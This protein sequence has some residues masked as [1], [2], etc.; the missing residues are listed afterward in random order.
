M[1]P[2]SLWQLSTDLDVDNGKAN[3]TRHRP[4]ELFLEVTLCLDLDL[5]KEIIDMNIVMKHVDHS[6]GDVIDLLQGLLRYDPS[7]SLMAREALRH[8][9][10]SVSRRGGDGFEVEEDEIFH[11]A[12]SAA[13]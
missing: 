6:A 5:Y 12:A 7:D 11:A 10:F 2:R 8:P 13:L 9:F 4:C 3:P 1:A